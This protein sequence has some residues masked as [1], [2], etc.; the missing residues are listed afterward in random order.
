MQQEIH[1]VLLQNMGNR[2]THELINGL[3][4]RLEMIARQGIA[5]A[6]KAHE[7]ARGTTG[8]GDA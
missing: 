5:D 1:Q 2:L 4:A 6:I 7:A 3:T 8:V